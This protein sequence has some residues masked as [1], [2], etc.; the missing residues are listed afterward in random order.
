MRISH[1]GPVCEDCQTLLLLYHANANLKSKGKWKKK[2]K[3][4][5]NMAKTKEHNK[6]PETNAN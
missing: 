5:E 6:S 3:K 2:E 4:Q 1:P